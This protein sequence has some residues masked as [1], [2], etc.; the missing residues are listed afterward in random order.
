M[1]TITFQSSDE[2]K[3]TV[4]LEVATYSNTIKTMLDDL[5]LEETTDA[6]PLPNV[7]GSIMEKVLEWAKH[8]RV[9]L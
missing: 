5:G 3:F 4:P 7:S 1:A 9:C 8:E 2:K 6:I